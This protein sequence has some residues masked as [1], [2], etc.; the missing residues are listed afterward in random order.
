[1]NTDA[2]IC[3]LIFLKESDKDSKCTLRKVSSCFDSELGYRSC[4]GVGAE[5][6]SAGQVRCCWQKHMRE[7]NLPLS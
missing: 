2:E 7:N 4:A 1:M 5:A 3:S 6:G